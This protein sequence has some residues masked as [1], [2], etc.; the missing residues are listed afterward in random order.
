MAIYMFLENKSPSLIPIA[1]KAR[2]PFQIMT[3][4]I[5][6]IYIY[7]HTL[8]E[9]QS[10]CDTVLKHIRVST[11]TGKIRHVKILMA[12][13][14]TGKAATK[15]FFRK[16]KLQ[17]YS[18]NLPLCHPPWHSSKSTCEFQCTEAYQR[19]STTHPIVIGAKVQLWHDKPMW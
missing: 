1:R 9:I 8:T 16:G 4:T 19:H 11:N 14:W 2:C 17:Y 7:T 5:T 6:G 3:E 15:K 13:L 10:T 18:W 12:S